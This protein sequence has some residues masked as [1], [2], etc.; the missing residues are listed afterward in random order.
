M[1]QSSDRSSTLIVRFS[2][3]PLV[4][5]NYDHIIPERICS[6]K[7]A[8][9]CNYGSLLLL[10]PCLYGSDVTVQANNWLADRCVKILRNLR[11]NSMVYRFPLDTPGMWLLATDVQIHMYIQDYCIPHARWQRPNNF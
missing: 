2:H 5:Q 11:I 8:Q 1:A 10:V 9:K 6:M 4:L 3:S 7:S